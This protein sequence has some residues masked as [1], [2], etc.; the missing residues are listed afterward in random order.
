M[1][2]D[3]QE[4]PVVYGLLNAQETRHFIRIQKGFLIEGNAYVAGGVPDSIYYPDVLT[5]K[6]TNLNSGQDFNLSRIN[7]DTLNPPLA[8]DSGAFA[9]SP[10]ILYTFN[11]NLNSSD[12]YKLEIINNENG[13]Q[14]FA[15]TSLV[16]DFSVF[17]P[18][19]GTRLN[20]I[21]VNPP[22]IRWNLAENGK[23]YDFTV[24]IH[25]T[26]HKISDAGY[27]KDTFIDVPFLRLE[28]ED[29][30]TG[31]Y[32]EARFSSDI[33]LRYMATRLKA[34]NDLY[35]EYDKVKGMHFIFGVGGTELGKYISSRYAQGGITS[36]EAL[37]PYTN[38]DGG[39]GLLSSRYFKTVDSLF[40]S[41]DGIDSLACQEVMKPLRFKNHNGVFCN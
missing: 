39:V 33:V 36:N 2:A 28:P 5:V 1:T 25:F 18:L 31:G 21:S 38:V 8:K 40:L 30:V 13:K 11:G 20:L 7:G 26:E 4:T 19:R 22:P 37:P 29:Y 14:I 27:S 12:S 24:R 34:D 10:N 6:L 23:L 16:K 15:S 32:Y 35:R 41:N 9:K 3:Y 17:L